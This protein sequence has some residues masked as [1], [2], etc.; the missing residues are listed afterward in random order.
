MGQSV[1]SRWTIVDMWMTLIK[2]LFP[3]DLTAGRWA[4]LFCF[5]FLVYVSFVCFVCVGFLFVWKFFVYPFGLRLRVCFNRL[6][7]V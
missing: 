1:E 5:V 3:R 2:R 4:V 7:L 6:E